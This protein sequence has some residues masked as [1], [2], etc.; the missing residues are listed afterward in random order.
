MRSNICAR[1]LRTARW[2]G[3]GSQQAPIHRKHVDVGRVREQQRGEGCN[4]RHASV[5]LTLAALLRERT[6][7]HA[8]KLRAERVVAHAE[9]VRARL[10]QRARE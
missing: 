6:S 7:A 4:Q 3:A 9:S 2:G 5:D 1:A 8:A 10:P